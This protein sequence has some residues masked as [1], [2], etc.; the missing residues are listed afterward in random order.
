MVRFNY[1][2]GSISY[3]FFTAPLNPAETVI[4]GFVGKL[5]RSFDLRDLDFDVRAA[6]KLGKKKGELEV[7][8]IRGQKV[9]LDKKYCFSVA[10]PEGWEVGMQRDWQEILLKRSYSSISLFLYAKGREDTAQTVMRNLGKNVKYKLL[11]KTAVH[12]SELNGYR[13]EYAWKYDNKVIHYYCVF[14]DYALGIY[15][16]G[17]TD[18]EMRRVFE[19]FKRTD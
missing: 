3:N 12:G 17:V 9:V 6:L 18:A 8:K 13:A 2:D 15:G 5:R 1:T 7:K 4:G 10:V 14:G 19:S 11:G 16:Y